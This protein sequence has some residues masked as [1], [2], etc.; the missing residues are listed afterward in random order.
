MDLLKQFLR[1]VMNFCQ[2]NEKGGC[3]FS[4]CFCGKQHSKPQPV[5]LYRK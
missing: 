1:V 2:I 4:V 3:Y 5:I